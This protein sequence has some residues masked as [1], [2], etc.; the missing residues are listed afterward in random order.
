MN[1]SEAKKASNRKLGESVCK[2]L[3]ARGFSAQYAESAE[4]ACERALEMIEEGATVGIP[5]TVTVREIG[6]MERL[7]EK[8]CKISEHWLPD[9]SPAER[10]AALLGELQADWFVT[11]ANA[12][13]MDGTIVNIDGAGNRVAVMSWAPGKIIYIVGINKISSDV[14]SAI[15]RARA[16]ASPPNALRLARKTPCT[17]TGHCMDCNSPER[18]CRVVTLIERAPLGRECHVIIVGE[19]LG[20]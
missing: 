16:I 7:E 1:T 10:T 12:L 20:Y 3:E 11:S 14:H 18:I 2:A 8:G 6:L 4:A 5:G 19:E 9:M 15:K 13:S 17:A